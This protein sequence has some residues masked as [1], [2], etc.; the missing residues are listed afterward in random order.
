[1]ALVLKTSVS[2]RA[3]SVR[4]RPSPCNSQAKPSHWLGF[5]MS[6][7]GLR[8]HSGSGCCT[9]NAY[10]EHQNNPDWVLQYNTASAHTPW[11]SQ[12]NQAIGHGILRR[13]RLSWVTTP[14]MLPK[15][16]LDES[17]KNQK[18]RT[19]AAGNCGQIIQKDS[20]MQPRKVT[21]SPT[22]L[23]QAGVASTSDHGFI[24][25]TSVGWC[26]YC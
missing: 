2:A 22:P 26:P 7:E 17:P 14:I 15:R 23:W 10:P 3:P 21:E 6:R 24:A 9:I 18:K 19:V 13:Y 4:I 20:R 16:N 8:S 1:M 25:K 5:L 11:R 12:Q